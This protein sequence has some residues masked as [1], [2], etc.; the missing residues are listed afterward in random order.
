MVSGVFS[1]KKGLCLEA[2]LMLGKSISVENSEI[3]VTIFYLC[4]FCGALPLGTVWKYLLKLAGEAEE[5]GF[6]GDLAKGK[7]LVAYGY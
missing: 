7:A 5:Y 2:F 3:V 1:L 4:D 6:L